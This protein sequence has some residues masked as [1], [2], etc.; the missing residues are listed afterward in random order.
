MELLTAQASNPSPTMD[1]PLSSHEQF[2]DFLKGAGAGS[3]RISRRVPMSKKHWWE[4]NPQPDFDSLYEGL[5]EE[6]ARVGRDFFTYHGEIDDSGAELLKFLLEA[7]FCALGI[8]IVASGFLVYLSLSF[9]RCLIRR[10]IGLFTERPPSL[11]LPQFDDTT[12]NHFVALSCLGL[13]LWI[14]AWMI[15]RSFQ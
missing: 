5:K 15:I 4:G 7:P 11:A 13:A 3:S 14:A 12:E 6:D 10:C 1:T 8:G 9:S 2:F